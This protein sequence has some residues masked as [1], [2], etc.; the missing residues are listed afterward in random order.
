[1]LRAVLSL[2]SG[3]GRKRMA[4]MV[5]RYWPVLLIIALGL[6]HLVEVK[7][8]YNRGFDEGEATRQ[9]AIDEETD[10]LNDKLRELQ[11]QIETQAEEL[12]RERI[13]TQSVERQLADEARRDPDADAPGINQS[14]RLRIEQIR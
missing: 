6:F 9:A 14:G 13:A 3:A 4:G 5:R 7:R 1:M 2:F 11:T 8:H 12:D 10:A